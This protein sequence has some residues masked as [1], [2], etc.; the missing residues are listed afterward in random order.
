MHALGFHRV[1]AG[2]IDKRQVPIAKTTQ[3][4]GRGF[5]FARS[6]WDHDE[7][8]HRFDHGENSH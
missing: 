3:Q 5:D 2:S 1:E 8:S 6:Y 7:R 4:R